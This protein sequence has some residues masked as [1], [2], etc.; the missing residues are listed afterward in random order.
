MI[1]V[2]SDKVWVGSCDKLNASA[3]GEA[4]LIS[5]SICLIRFSRKVSERDISGREQFIRLT[6]FLSDKISYCPDNLSN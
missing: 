4:Y 5:G 6:I 3:K 1:R 2:R